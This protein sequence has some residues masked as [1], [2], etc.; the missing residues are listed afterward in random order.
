MPWGRQAV[1]IQQGT[2]LVNSIRSFG[3]G[4]LVAATIVLAGCVSMPKQQAYNRDAHPTVKRIQMLETAES[5]TSVF[6]LNNPGASFGLIGGLIAAADQAS[7]E[8]KF[9]LILQQAQFDPV[10]YFRDQLN[11]RLSE[12]GYEVVMPATAVEVTKHPRAAAFGLRKTYDPVDADAQLDV[13]FGFVGYAAA[14]A[15]SSSPYRPT[16]TVGARL[17]G[18]DGKQNYFTDY[19]AYNNVFNMKDAVALNP[20]PQYAY[21]NF[22]ALQAAG[23]TTVEG[24]KTAIDNV[25][26]AVAQQL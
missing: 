17:V 15:S 4:L 1:A 6:M 24:L 3:R 9:S 25:A 22:D 2:S 7:K 11:K 23:P 20:D 12:K 21:A 18:P 13:N 16:V 26:A 14:G 5:R 8:K 19:F 10:L